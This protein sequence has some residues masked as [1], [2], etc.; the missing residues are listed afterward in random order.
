MKKVFIVFIF[1]LLCLFSLDFVLAE[2]K[3]V[4]VDEVLET[5]VLN[6]GIEYKKELIT[7]TQYKSSEKFQSKV[8]SLTM[9][10]N[11]D[12]VK[13]ATWSYHSTYNTT[14]VSLDKIAQDYEK[15][16][17]G[18]IVVGG[19]NSE[20]WWSEGGVS[21][22]SNTY[23]T[24]TDIVRPGVSSESFKE[25]IGIYPDN[26]IYV[27]RFPK[28]SDFMVLSLYDNSGNLIKTLNVE[29]LDKLP[30]G[31]EISVITQ[32]INKTFDVTGY[33]VIEGGYN[34]FRKPSYFIDGT[35]NIN[36]TPTDG[37]LLKGTIDGI[38]SESS[39]KGLGPK[40]Y[41]ITKSDSKKEDI[42]KG[43]TLR[44]QYEFVDEFKNTPNI[45]GYMFKLIENGNVITPD[46]YQDNSAAY[47]EGYTIGNDSFYYREHS[48][49]TTHGK[50]RSCVGFKEDGGIVLL[51]AITDAG[52]GPSQY[53]LSNILKEKGCSTAYQFDGGG[54]VTMVKRNELGHFELVTNTST[55]ITTGLFFVVKDPTFKAVESSRSSITFSYDESIISNVK[56]L[57]DGKTYTLDSTKTVNDLPE[58]TNIEYRAIYDIKSQ[59]QDKVINT[60]SRLQHY[61]TLS[62][63]MPES[64]LSIDKI[65]KNTITIK[66]D[67]DKI[68]NVIVHVGDTDYNMGNESSF[69]C[70]GLIDETDYNV[71]FTYSVLDDETGKLYTATTDVTSI[72]TLS[73]NLPSIELFN[74]YK[75]LEDGKLTL[76]YKYVDPDRKVDKAYIICNNEYI[77][78]TIKSGKEK[79][80]DITSSTTAILTLEYTDDLG[81]TKNINSEVLEITVETKEEENNTPTQPTENKETKKGCK[82]KKTLLMI[83]IIN[84]ISLIGIILFKKNK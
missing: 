24:D 36:G 74:I 15:N 55:S 33:N 62:F 11:D 52:G 37:I 73:Y 60:S 53:E 47:N 4:V 38:C 44:I 68:I 34:L 59:Y 43:A 65:S 64:S 2:A 45:T 39:I 13:L 42:L 19:V 70:D 51:T 80:E 46:T 83:S 5:E 25:L 48:Y 41:L 50:R 8:F 20:G 12:A 7:T 82:K 26:S 56:V 31:D 75:P 76:E 18:W 9:N 10:G 66:K 32:N 28:Y 71:S 81:E 29:N 77:E 14:N 54:S 30:E 58:D 35:Y 69:V 61:K 84:T 78:L 79:I 23:V 27:K 22:I 21:Q 67:N 3:Q 17:P 57:I 72:K 49:A 1:S 40:F 63:K 16:H 6:A